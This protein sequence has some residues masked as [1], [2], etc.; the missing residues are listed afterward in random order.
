MEDNAKQDI[1]TDLAKQLGS[2]IYITKFLDGRVDIWN[3]GKLLTAVYREEETL[4]ERPRLKQPVQIP[5]VI[6][7]ILCHYVKIS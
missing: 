3:F 6:R 7:Y 5:N 4:R 1:P 2:I